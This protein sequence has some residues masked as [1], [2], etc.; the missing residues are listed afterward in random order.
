MKLSLS[1]VTLLLQFLAT[2]VAD[3]DDVRMHNTLDST[4]PTA[5]SNASSNEKPTNPSLDAAHDR[6]HQHSTDNYEN[7]FDVDA[8]ITIRTQAQRVQ[9]SKTISDNGTDGRIIE[10]AAEVLH[11]DSL[12]AIPPMIPA[13]SMNMG[14][15]QSDHLEVVVPTDA[16]VTGI[17]SSGTTRTD[18]SREQIE[19]SS[20]DWEEIEE[21]EG[22]T[23]SGDA[24]HEP[25]DGDIEHSV[26][27]IIPEISEA[28]AEKSLE[29][30]QTKN[31]L[32][33]DV[34]I[35]SQK[36]D[37]V[38]PSK[39]GEVDDDDDDR[40]PNEVVVDYANKSTGAI[41]L[42]KSPNFK[43]TGNLLLSNNDR[44]AISPC[45]EEGTKYVIIGLSEDIQVNTIKLSSYERYSSTTRKFEVLGSTTYPISSKWEK[46]GTFEAKPW[47]KENGEQTF[48][49]EHPSW[50]RYL[51]F[52]FITHYGVEHYCTVT[53]VKVHG[54]T[55]QQGFHMQWD[56]EENNQEED[57]VVAQKDQ[58]DATLS[59]MDIGDEGQTIEINTE[60][61]SIVSVISEGDVIDNTNHEIQTHDGDEISSNEGGNMEQSD[62]LA[63]RKGVSSISMIQ[64][65]KQIKEKILKRKKH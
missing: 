39:E 42:D 48:E 19:N 18:G 25:L 12:T 20:V 7:D 60:M 11:D 55:T 17:E 35:E 2:L 9:L 54:S 59:E 56:T 1:R 14:R 37:T 49:L 63:D 32:D 22:R 21:L 15:I 16:E 62:E 26:E 27:G 23:D 57:E 45:E 24:I 46:L 10:T 41:I 34:E 47:F 5:I 3:D 50:C 33:E 53:Q 64:Q 38:I 43:G 36:D 40:P 52:R 30:D 6:L 31:E 58:A 65:I 28:W 8:S 61:T 51:K 29:V 4:L 44:Y 13:E